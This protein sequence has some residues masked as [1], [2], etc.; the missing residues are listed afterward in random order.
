VIT[1]QRLAVLEDIASV[2]NAVTVSS[3]ELRELLRA[4]RPEPAS[5]VDPVILDEEIEDT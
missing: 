5:I 2:S 1:A 4:Y 3:D